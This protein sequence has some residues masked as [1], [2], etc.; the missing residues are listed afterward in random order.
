MAF[1]GFLAIGAVNPHILIPSPPL[2]LFNL[3]WVRSWLR[4]EVRENDISFLQTAWRTKFTTLVHF[5][6]KDKLNRLWS[7]KVKVQGYD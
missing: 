2:E 7:Q 3:L 5:G 1:R 6:D 4:P